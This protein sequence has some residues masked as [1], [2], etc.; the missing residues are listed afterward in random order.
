MFESVVPIKNSKGEVLLDECY[1]K[2]RE[3]NNY[4]D[5]DFI[6]VKPYTGSGNLFGSFNFNSHTIELIHR[7][8]SKRQLIVVVR[9]SDDSVDIY[10]FQNVYCGLFGSYVKKQVND[11]NVILVVLDFEQNNTYQFL[12]DISSNRNVALI[13]KNEII[14]TQ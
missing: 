11:Q 10:N 8:N 12:I 4:S 1:E 6:D 9:D 3:L 14:S 7:S 2:R 5:D 13:C